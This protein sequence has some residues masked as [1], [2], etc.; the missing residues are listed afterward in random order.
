MTHGKLPRKRVAAITALLSS[1][2]VGEA[3]QACGLSERTLLRWLKDSVFLGAY[4]EAQR[5][6]F[7]DAVNRLRSSATEFISVLRTVALDATA[8]PAARASA[9]RSGL[10]AW[11]KAISL[12]DLEGRISELE[13]NVAK[14]DQ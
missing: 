4:R 6:L 7:E 3:A 5:R 13:R 10:D 12:A 11:L 2:T 9:S 1:R 14:G 8:P